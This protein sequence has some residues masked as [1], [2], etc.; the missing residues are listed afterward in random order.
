MIKNN[1]KFIIGFILGV[2]IFTS[3]GVCAATLINSREVIYDNTNSKLES[4]NVQD[5]IDE[6][7]KNSKLKNRDNI[8]EAYTYNQISGAKN[9]CVTGDEDTCVETTC[10]ES[11]TAGSCPAG[12]IVIYKLNE[13]ETGRFHVMFDNGTT[14]TMQSQRNTVY[15]IPWIDK[16]DYATENTD[17][18]VCE[19]ESCTDEGP[20]TI[21]NE[22]ESTTAGWTNVNTLTYTLGTTV[23]KTSSYT[24]CNDD[25]T[26]TENKYTLPERT[27]KARIITV[28]EAGVLGC[29]T[30]SCPIWM[31]NYLK[32]S[33]NKGGTINDTSTGPKGESNAAYWTVSVPRTTNTYAYYI[34]QYAH[35]S[36]SA[37]YENYVGARAVVEINK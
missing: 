5:A 12:T 9:Y 16:A 10:Y 37:I 31:Y 23:F 22:L 19:T 20:I 33:T 1:K 32:E 8:V 30:S 17:G 7:Y 15:N 13:N 6:L 34:N 28:Q 36:G 3:I 29:T 14:L 26:C 35:V 2:I 18:T 4:S 27:G 24:G 11:T 21:L 25:T